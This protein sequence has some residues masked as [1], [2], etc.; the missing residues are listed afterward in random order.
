MVVLVSLWLSAESKQLSSFVYKMIHVPK[1]ALF[2]S[3]VTS[4]K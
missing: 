3:D 4:R 1:D 2:C